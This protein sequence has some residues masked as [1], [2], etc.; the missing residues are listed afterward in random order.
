MSDEG[1]SLDN[2]EALLFIL[3]ALARKRGG[4]LRVSKKDILS[5]S[6]NEVLTLGYDSKTQDL[7]LKTIKSVKNEELN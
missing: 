1:D 5:V 3:A 6:V 7:V 2:N 4:E